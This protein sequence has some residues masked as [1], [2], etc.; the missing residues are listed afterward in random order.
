MCDNFSSSK[1]TVLIT[2][3]PCLAHDGQEI[4]VIPRCR[5]PRDFKISYPTFTSSTVSADNETR[6]VSQIPDQSKLPSPIDDL[7]VPLV[8]PQA[9]VMPICN[10]A[11]VASDKPL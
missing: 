3:N 5:N 6:K 10:G 11:S 7:I 2:S 4:I 1:D 9:S 8:N